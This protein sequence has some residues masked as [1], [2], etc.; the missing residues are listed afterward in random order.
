MKVII[1]IFCAEM[2]KINFSK[3]RTNQHFRKNFVIG[4][5]I[6]CMS[7]SC[8]TSTSESKN[9][10]STESS[11]AATE[12]FALQKGM[13]TSS[14][15][16]PGELIAFQQVDIYAKENSFVKKMYVDVGSEVTTGQ[17]LATMEAPELNSQL[18]AASSKLKAQEALYIASKANYDRLLETSKTPGTI[19][20]NDLDLAL[21]KMNSDRAQLD[22]AKA[23]YAEVA[24]TKDYLEIRAPF[25][26]VISARNVN[27]GAYVGPSG[28]GSEFPLFTLQEQKKL[29]LVV[30]IPE[31]YTSY[32]H[33]NDTISFTVI[34]FPNQQFTA[35]VKRLAGAL[36]ERLRS[37]RTE[38]DVMNDDKKL[39][40]GM[41]ADVHIPLAAKDSTFI[42]PKSA[43][44]NSTERVFV[45]KISNNKVQWMD[46]K[47][48]REANGKVE[49]FG[50]LSSGDSLV[51]TASEEIRDG[52]TISEVKQVQAQ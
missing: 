15:Q 37:Q 9:K 45:I 16:I 10:T 29:R 21:A 20:P 27:A 50:D 14:L 34:A 1:K 35:H 46:V 11:A 4:F 38:M 43:I 44:V 2:K 48:G 22:A 52:S 28:K 26:G 41:V 19:A 17:L 31:A 40:P 49:I 25:N 24:N 30:S 6:L 42:V 7:Q 47:K 8:H 5:L 23:A 3:S 51:K 32:L 13:L 33:E 36:D 12:V 18:S 39:L